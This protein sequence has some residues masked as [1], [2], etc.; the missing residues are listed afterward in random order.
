MAFGHKNIPTQVVDIDEGEDDGEAVLTHAEALARGILAQ[1]QPDEAAEVIPRPP[2]I[3]KERRKQRVENAQEFIRQQLGFGEDGDEDEV[4][5]TDDDDEE[6]EEER[7]A[8]TRGGRRRNPFID[9]ECGV[10]RRRLNSD[11]D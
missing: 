7:E 10:S 5:E 2:C 4:V 8:P 1:R 6:E 11:S 9:S 3:W